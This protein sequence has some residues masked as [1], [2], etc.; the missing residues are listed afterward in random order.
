MLNF[1]CGES[2][3]AFGSIDKGSGY[4]KKWCFETGLGISSHPCPLWVLP[5]FLPSLYVTLLNVPMIHHPVGSSFLSLSSKV[6]SGY[7]SSP[8]SAVLLPSCAHWCV[9]VEL[10]G[11]CHCD[12]SVP[13]SNVLC[14]EEAGGFLKSRIQP[15]L[16]W[17]NISRTWVGNQTRKG[18][19][20]DGAI[21]GRPSMERGSL[22]N[23]EAREKCWGL[24]NAELRSIHIP[25]AASARP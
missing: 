10:D 25:L 8:L 22:K 9:G 21:W 23:L 14:W 5:I 6:V 1:I 18:V 2:R 12:I 24:E 20:K 3:S 4:F 13:S 17:S 15:A 7:H 11:R 16:T 19:P